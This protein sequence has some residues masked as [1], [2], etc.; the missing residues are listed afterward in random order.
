MRQLPQLWLRRPVLIRVLINFG[1]AVKL[2]LDILFDTGFTKR[3]MRNPLV[4]LYTYFH[5]DHN[6]M[7]KN[8]NEQS[9]ILSML[10]ELAAILQCSNNFLFHA[11]RK[12]RDK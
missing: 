10:H 12:D 11:I 6:E 7:G 2:K 9:M 4:V 8:I 5:H 1:F 3:E